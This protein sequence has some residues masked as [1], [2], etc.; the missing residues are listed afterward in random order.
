MDDFYIIHLN[1]V[2][3][4]PQYILERYLAIE[5]S[6]NDDSQE[7]LNKRLDKIK[8]MVKFEYKMKDRKWFDIE[9][10]LGSVL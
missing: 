5:R 2:T 7:I 3:K 9:E 10:F 8:Q 1:V 6:S 4:A